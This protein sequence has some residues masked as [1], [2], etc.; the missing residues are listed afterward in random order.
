M[1]FMGL[2]LFKSSQICKKK[3]LKHLELLSQGFL[4]LMR[5]VRTAAHSGLLK[6]APMLILGLLK[7][8]TV[9]CS[10]TVSRE[11]ERVGL[12][13]KMHQ[14]HMVFWSTNCYFRGLGFGYLWMCDFARISGATSQMNGSTVCKF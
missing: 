8:Q 13:P 4:A 6:S 5:G 3:F 7:W 10:A 1:T 12:S 14:N 2:A 11:Q 9:A